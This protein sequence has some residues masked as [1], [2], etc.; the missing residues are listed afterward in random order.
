MLCLSEQVADITPPACAYL[1]KRYLFRMKTLLGLLIILVCMSCS[2][3]V[4][5]MEADPVVNDPLNGATGSDNTELSSVEG[6]TSEAIPDVLVALA[7][8]SD[9]LSAVPPIAHTLTMADTGIRI[10][11]TDITQLSSA[12]AAQI[13]LQWTYMQECVQLVA[14]PPLVL[15]RSKRIEP[16]TVNDDVVRNET[17]MATQINSVPIAS[18]STVEGNVIQISVDDFDGALGSPLFNLRSIMGRHLWFASGLPERDY[19]YW[20]AVDQPS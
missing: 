13:E 10:S 20:C 14:S 6:G 3:S 1:R 7:Q 15:V 4:K 2:E 8:R 19:P 5:H 9:L 18:A 16:F 12:P 11:Y 17:L